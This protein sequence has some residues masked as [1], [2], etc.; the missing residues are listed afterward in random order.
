MHR[1]VEG[2]VTD[3]ACRSGCSVERRWHHQQ[4]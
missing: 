4:W 3:R 1:K 2:E